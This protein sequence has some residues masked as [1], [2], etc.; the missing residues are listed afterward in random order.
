MNGPRCQPD[1]ATIV[2]LSARG[3]DRVKSGHPWVYR[4]DVRKSSAEPGDL[5][6]VE[7]ERGRPLGTALWSSTS[8][9]SLRFLGPDDVSDEREM[10]RDRLRA[11]LAFRDTL[12]ID[13][14]ALAGRQRRGA[15]GYRASS[16][17]CTATL[18][19]LVIRRV[20]QGRAGGSSSCR[21]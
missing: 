11:A 15:T 1:A 20:A 12:A 5:V 6:R 10:F 16:W 17:T 9:I 2:T 21:R 19:L 8:Q 7:S 4:S 14:T 13:A 3:A 18:R